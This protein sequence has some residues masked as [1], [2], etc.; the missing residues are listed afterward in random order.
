MYTYSFEKLDVWQL[1]REFT[2]DLYKITMNFPNDE[3]FG[4]TNQMRRASI[5]ICSN[6][7][8]G[9]ARQTYKEKARFFQMSYGS[10]VE[11]LNQL[12]NS[13]DLNYITSEELNMLRE[14]IEKITNM[15]N[16]LHKSQINKSS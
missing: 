6:I 5:S 4:I 13:N 11:L 10:A 3:L 14:K 8:E 2:S 16:A 7:A 12:I 1:A 9:A 15:L